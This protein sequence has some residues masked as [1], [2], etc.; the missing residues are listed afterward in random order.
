VSAAHL[1]PNSTYDLVLKGISHGVAINATVASNIAT[2][3]GGN[4][5]A[6]TFTLPQIPG[7]NAWALVAMPHSIFIYC[8]DTAL[9]T[10]LA[11]CLLRPTGPDTNGMFSVVFDGGSGW[12]PGGTVTYTVHVV[13]DTTATVAVNQDGSL[14]TATINA[15][16]VTGI[17]PTFQVNGPSVDNPNVTLTTPSLFTCP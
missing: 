4:I 16:C 6:Q 9:V 7:H 14:D 1:A 11:V 12:L 8:P 17:T 5:P 13:G 15:Q 3:A 2:D 10:S